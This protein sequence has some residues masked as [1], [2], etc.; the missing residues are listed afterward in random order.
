MSQSSDPE[1][2]S[3]RWCDEPIGHRSR[4]VQYVGEIL[5]ADGWQPVQSVS[6]TLEAGPAQTTPGLVLTV[7]A[8]RPSRYH[9][10]MLPWA[11]VEKLATMLSAAG[12]KYG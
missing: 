4:H 3:V 9:A 5:V 6:V 8:S 2:C 10:V 12:K 7:A 11:Q 1:K